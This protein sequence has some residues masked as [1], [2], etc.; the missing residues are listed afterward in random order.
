MRF[1]TARVKSESGASI[2]D[3]Y[4]QLVQVLKRELRIPIAV[5]IGPFFS[6]LPH[7]ADAMVRA[8]ADGLVL[9]N[10]YLAPDI[11]LEDMRF[12]PA[13][14]LSTPDELRLALR[15]IAILRDNVQI[16]LAATGG[17]HSAHDVVKSLLV[18]ANA[19]A[20]ASALLSRGAG[21]LTELRDGLESWMREHD[22]ANLEQLRGSMSM[23]KCPNP[24]GLI[25][26]NYMKA[27]TSY[28]PS[29]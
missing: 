6:S 5:K 16:S 14:E 1:Q 18:G 13:L 17:I 8:G 24:E 29:V 27:L 21:V 3:T 19:V 10:R 15:W 28:T 23:K 9:F 25:R 11:D 2:D 4:V 12:I 22:Y 26:A 7:L 20:C